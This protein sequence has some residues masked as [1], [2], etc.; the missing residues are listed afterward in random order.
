MERTQL[1][2]DRQTDRQTDG[3]LLQKHYISYIYIYERHS[4]INYNNRFIYYG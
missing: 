2:T 1:V 3:Q 4:Y